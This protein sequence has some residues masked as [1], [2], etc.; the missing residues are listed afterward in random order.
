MTKRWRIKVRGKV[1]GVFYRVSTAEKATALGLV[2]WV[3]N[4]P[5]GSVLLEVEGDDSPLTTFVN[6]LSEGPPMAVVI[7]VD[8]SE[9][10]V[11]GSEYKF[12]VRY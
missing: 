6:W 5:D 8:Q 9:I 10:A 4:E 3:K 11:L 12:E 1:Q 7:G 2:G